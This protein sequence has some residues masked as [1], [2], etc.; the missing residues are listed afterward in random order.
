MTDCRARVL[1][2]R[3]GVM[4]RSLERQVGFTVKLSDFTTL[5]NRHRS[6]TC[7]LTVIR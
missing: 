6:R 1:Q 4:F 2:R 7:V 3:C 5:L